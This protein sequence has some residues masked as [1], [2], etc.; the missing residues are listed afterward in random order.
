M[1]GACGG[2]IIAS[3]AVS[4]A[5][6]ADIVIDSRKVC[7]GAVFVA[8]RGERVDGHSFIPQA[9]EKG[10]MLDY[11]HSAMNHAMVITGVN[12][13]NGKPNRW[14]IE[15]SWGTDGP[16][17]GYYFMSDKW[18]DSYVFQ[19]V[20]HK[21]YLGDKAALLKRKPVV[22]KPWDPMGTLAD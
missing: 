17:K 11:R 6:A 1:A 13:V 12:V 18:F 10:A 4:G 22:L 15:N 19:A 7:P 9:F 2:E 16:N 8:T 21:K 3:A 5:E 20:V 14:K